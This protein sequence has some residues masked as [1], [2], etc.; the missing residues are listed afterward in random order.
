MAGDITETLRRGLDEPSATRLEHMRR[1]YAALPPFDA[2][3]IID[4]GCGRGGPTL[5]L[6]RLGGGEIVGVDIDRDAL[7]VLEAR[8]ADAG[9]ADRISVRCRSM[10]EPG[11]AH[12][13]FDIVWSEG[14]AHILGLARS[15]DAWGPLVRPGGGLVIHDA[16]WMRA[17]P[18]APVVAQWRRFFPDVDTVAGFAEAITRR[19]DVLLDAFALPE[20]HWWDDYYGPLEARVA[21]ARDRCGGDAA[22]LAALRP[23]TE[24]IKAFRRSRPWF[25]SAYF[26][27]RR[28]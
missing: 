28:D 20:A 10:A 23:L 22:T 9:L 24:E 8:A 16:V 7:D 25:G 14:S 27:M 11:D 17:E 13:A 21:E 3:R 15:L 2:P 1:A 6:A 19:G 5:E 26:V 4:M 12:G 18:P